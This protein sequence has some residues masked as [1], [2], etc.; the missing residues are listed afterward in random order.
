MTADKLY[1]ERRL[2]VLPVSYKIKKKVKYTT[3][4]L[5]RNRKPQHASH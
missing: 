1:L 3:L 2:A 5:A 4:F